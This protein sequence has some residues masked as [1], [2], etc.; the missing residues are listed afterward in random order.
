MTEPN[1]FAAPFREMAERI[2]RNLP[3][4]FAG[5][6]LIVPPT[7]DPIAVMIADPKK[8]MEAFWGVAMAKI[9]IATNE[10][11]A[12]KIGGQHGFNRR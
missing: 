11:Q 2:E 12:T 8:D 3:E 6:I 5:A 4:E 1:K 10:F 7:G 9:Q